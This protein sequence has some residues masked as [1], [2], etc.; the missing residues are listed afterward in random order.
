M[1]K[2]GFYFWWV[3]NIC[4]KDARV[5][6]RKDDHWPY[7]FDIYRTGPRSLLWMQVELDLRELLDLWGN[8]VSWYSAL[9]TLSL[10]NY[11]SRLDSF[12]FT[13][14]FLWA[15]YCYSLLHLLDDRNRTS[16]KVDIELGWRMVSELKNS[17]LKQHWL[18]WM[19]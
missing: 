15:I 10:Y 1:F 17:N 14:I 6:L 7:Y 4:A 9:Q 19:R 2:Y 13:Y 8:L 16:F 11:A 12:L 18:Y 5:D 3:T